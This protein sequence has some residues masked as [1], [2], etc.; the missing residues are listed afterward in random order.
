MSK[1]RQALKLH[2]QGESKLQIAAVTG[3]SRNTLKKY[4]RILAAYKTIW[5]DLEQLTDKQLD[6]LFC[7]EPEK[8][9]D[10]RLS[11]LHEYFTNHNKRLRKRGMTLLR[12]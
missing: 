7:K 3:I 11:T 4:L 1:L 8:I 10:E 5:Q 2:F 12:L 6:E 9:V